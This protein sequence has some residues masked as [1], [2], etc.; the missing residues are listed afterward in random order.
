MASGMGAATLMVAAG[1][2]M[3]AVAEQ[4]GHANP[5]RTANVY[6]H[7]SLASQ[8]AALSVLDEAVRGR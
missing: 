7:V 1:V 6:S 3:R 5:S 4:L 2:P 8:R